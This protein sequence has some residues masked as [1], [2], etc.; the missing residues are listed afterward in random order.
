[1]KRTIFSF[2]MVLISCLI[3]G[4]AR[5]GAVEY[6][7]SQQ[8]AAVIELPYSPD[9]VKAAMS[10]Y[11]SK[12]GKSKGTDL[13]G[14][15]T[16]RNTQSLQSDSANA[17]LYFKVERKSRKEKETSVLS[18]LL[19]MPKDDAA[20]SNNLHFLNMEQAKNYLNDLAPAIEA[21]NLE[22]VIKDQN[23]SV[24]KAESKFKSLND[25]GND[26][27][28]KRLAIE[29]KIQDNKRE[30]QAQKAEVE[31]QKQKLTSWVGQRKS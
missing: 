4:Q 19:T 16:Y 23:K 1:M 29:R 10:D 17:D 8:P 12:K 2:C 24:M 25:E 20:N 9:I 22:L 18:L 6:Q 14:F 7:K 27:E 11:L 13:K 21:Y 28:Q 30:Q 15:T 26:L 5:E 31:N 3:Y